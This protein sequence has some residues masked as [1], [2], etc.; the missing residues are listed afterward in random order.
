MYRALVKADGTT[1]TPVV[2]ELVP[3]PDPEFDHSVLG[4]RAEAPIAFEA[5]TARKAASRLIGCL[6]CGQTPDDLLETLHALVGLEF[7]LPSPR[8]ITEEPQV[9]QVERRRRMFRRASDR[10]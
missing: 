6:L 7:G 3:V 9:Q 2:V 10:R 8:R 4:A 5:V 1:G